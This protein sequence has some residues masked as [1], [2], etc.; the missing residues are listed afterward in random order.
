MVHSAIMEMEQVAHAVEVRGI[1][2]AF[3]ATQALAGVDLTLLP[4]R[5]HALLG[6]NGCGKSTL[7]KVLAGYHVPD[8]GEII[9]P[10]TDGASHI[11]F[12]HQD[13]GLVA[14]LSVAEN[15]SLTA[16]FAIQGGRIDWDYEYF[17]T[18]KLLR[19]YGVTCDPRTQV[20]DLGPTDQT[21]VAIVRALAILPEH[22]GILVLDEPTARL[23][24][25]E[26]DRL[27]EMLQSLKAR[28]VAILYIS[29]RLEEVLKLAD[30]L[31][32]LRDGRTVHHGEVAELDR[33][34]LVRL[35]IGHDAATMDEDAPRPDR[36]SARAILEVSELSGYR[37]GGA[38]LE[39]A[40]GELLGIAGLVG[41]GR[42]ELGRLIFGLQRATSGKILLEGRDVT[43]MSVPQH[44]RAGIAYVPQ[45]RLSGIFKGLSVAENAIV[46]ELD[47]L[48]SG[49]TISEGRCNAAAGGVIRSFQVK[50]PDMS[51][52]IETLSGGNQQKVVLGK[53]L[54]RDLRL[55]ILD[56]PTQGIDVGART[57]IFHIIR[58]VAAERNIAVLVMDSDLEILSEHCDRICIMA[59]GRIMNEF[60]GPGVPITTL[61]RAIYGH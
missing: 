42:S 30:E 45:D 53:W 16:G 4:G 35:I 12:V 58:K 14:T 61:N 3:G 31:T 60:D 44:V 6:A 17:A 38:N 52:P 43:D 32:V 18:G 36:G 20:G 27:I 23:P 33:K 7:V 19:K 41:S 50:S 51:V 34:D 26:A 48:V 37:V 8:A 22:G 10:A 5:V 40:G 47:S 11:A 15:L 25:A 21:M 1:R 59:A 39:V 55:L 28:G 29:H 13:L 24:A 46:A 49:L 54:R 56:E 2:K 9:F 57:D